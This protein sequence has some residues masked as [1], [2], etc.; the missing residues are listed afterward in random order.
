M[1]YWAY[2]RSSFVG[3]FIVG[4]V[5]LL[6]CFVLVVGGAG[7]PLALLVALMAVVA[8][9]AASVASWLQRRAFYADLERSA[10]DVQHP[11]WLAE[12][13]DRPDF[14]EGELTYDA[15]R[16]ISKA[17]NDDV[18]SY[19]RQAADYRE[20]V[21]TWVHEAK[22]PLAAA[23]LM[24][25]NLVG[26]M[27]ADDAADTALEKAEALEEELDRLE[28]YIEQALFFA[29]S[30]TLDRDYLIRKHRL[31]DLVSAAIKANARV[32]I[33]AR[34]IPVQRN[35]D[36]EVF[37]DDKWMEFILGQL[38]QNS[39]KYARD[40]GATIE[41]RG[42]LAAEG[43]A[44]ECVVLTVS[45]NGCGVPAADVPRVFDKGFTGE[46]GRTGKRST[47]I[48]LYL[49][50][51]LCDKMGIGVEAQSDEGRGFTATLTFP[52]NKM[53]YFERDPQKGMA[54]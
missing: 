12:M 49:V 2:L 47:G 28:G 5:A 4:S 15:L 7:W 38:I 44:D 17:A 35:L 53:H 1:S 42:A 41:F 3:A 24:L 32:M 52:A 16:A 9:L 30:E 33:A 45:D 20:Y 37:T 14:I 13:V 22:S 26:S 27:P 11:L 10:S 51:R 46:N 21:E 43:M 6:I 8:A 50:K 48:G 18:A 54:P 31:G 36:I 29:R 25:E 39:V 40:E 19:R 34:V 23:H